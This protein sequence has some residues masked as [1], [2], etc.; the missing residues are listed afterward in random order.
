MDAV[1][2]LET[3][4]LL[5]FALAWPFS[6]MKSWRAR[7]T[8]GKSIGFLAVILTGYVAGISKV[9]IS[10]GFGGFLLIPYT[11]NFALVF[12]DTL[13]YFRNKAIDRK[14]ELKQAENP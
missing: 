2:I 14:N 3:I 11:F 12:T 4:M 10:E 13:L 8:K 7:T 6:I 9:L 1:K 5:C